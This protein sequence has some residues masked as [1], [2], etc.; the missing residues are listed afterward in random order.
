MGVLRIL[1][2]IAVVVFAVTDFK[3]GWINGWVSVFTIACSEGG[4]ATVRTTEAAR[5]IGADGVPILVQIK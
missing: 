1:D 2:Q 4:I 5:T 3:G